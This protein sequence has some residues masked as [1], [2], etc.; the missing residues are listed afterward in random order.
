MRRRHQRGSALI[1]LALSS[2]LLVVILMGAV[3]IGYSIYRY[4]QAEIA[5]YQAARYAS[6][7]PFSDR[8]S[9]RAVTAVKNMV[10]Y[11]EP[12]PANGAAPRLSGV[13]PEDVAVEYQLD[14]R[15]VPVNVALSIGRMNVESI[16]G[17]LTLLDK[18]TATVPYVGPFAPHSCD[19]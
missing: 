13:G 15:G 3:D 14:S 4:N 10:L 18:P 17:S 5:V 19:E 2:T 8:C 12:K 7:R 16:L 9:V 1:E 11:G 6:S